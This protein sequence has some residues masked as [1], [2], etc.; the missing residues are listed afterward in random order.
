MAIKAKKVNLRCKSPDKP[1]YLYL[2]S[3]LGG[4][5]VYV[6]RHLRKFEVPKCRPTNDGHNKQSAENRTMIE[7]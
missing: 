3:I 4:K 6:C 1:I 5:S 2:R 7:G